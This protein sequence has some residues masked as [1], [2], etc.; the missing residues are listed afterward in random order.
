[1][2]A[3]PKGIGLVPGVPLSKGRGPRIL[4]EAHL[5]V[6]IFVWEA[7]FFLMMLKYT[8]WL[9]SLGCIE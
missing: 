7:I 1:M 2:V 6:S 8:R 9:N 5:R 3:C 4:G